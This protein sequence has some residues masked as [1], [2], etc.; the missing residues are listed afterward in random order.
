MAKETIDSRSKEIEKNVPFHTPSRDC[1]RM[2]RQT[3]SIDVTVISLKERED[4]SD[5]RK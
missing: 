1:E 5:E 4:D 3:P 2:R